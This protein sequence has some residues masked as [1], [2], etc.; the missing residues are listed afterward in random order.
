MEITRKRSLF[1]IHDYSVTGPDDMV[2]CA[3]CYG[4]LQDWE[5]GDN[6]LKEHARFFASC[7]KF[8]ER[9][10]VNASALVNRHHTQGEFAMPYEPKLLFFI[11]EYFTSPSV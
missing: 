1:N 11:F 4:K 5:Q 10:K 6:P 7:P 2:Q 3:W 9:G 8:G